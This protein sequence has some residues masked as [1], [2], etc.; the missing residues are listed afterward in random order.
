MYFPMYCT[1]TGEQKAWRSPHWK[2]PQD[3][4]LGHFSLLSHLPGS[5]PLEEATQEV[6]E[7]PCLR[8][9]SPPHPPYMVTWKRIN[10]SFC[11]WDMNLRK[12]NS[13]V[14]SI[15]LVFGI[16]AARW[17]DVTRWLSMASKGRSQKTS[18]ES[19]GSPRFPVTHVWCHHGGAQFCGSS[20]CPNVAMMKTWQP[21]RDVETPWET[22]ASMAFT[23]KDPGGIAGLTHW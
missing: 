6:C 12:Q 21:S 17:V 4:I 20:L 16:L 11:Q 14:S 1:E 3:H 19:V 10:T 7:H 15:L 8:Q 18:Q 9:K 5:W 2:P 23:V 22:W 13:K